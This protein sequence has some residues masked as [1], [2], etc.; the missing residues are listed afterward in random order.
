MDTKAV[1][2]GLGKM[3]RMFGGLAA[4]AGKA[5]KMGG[6]GILAGAGMIGAAAAAVGAITIGTAKWAKNLKNISNQTGVSVKDTLALREAFKAAGVE[7]SDNADLISDFQEKIEDAARGG[8]TGAEGYAMLGLT[9]FGL[10]KIRDPMR[11]FQVLMEAVEHSQ[12]SVQGRAFALD[13]ILGGQGF[14]FVHLAKNYSSFMARARKD[15]EGLANALDDKIMGELQDV[16]RIVDRI[17]LQFRFGMIQIA[18]ALP[19]DK[20]TGL[21]DKVL[22]L[23]GSFLTDPVGFLTEIWVQIDRDIKALIRNLVDALTAGFESILPKIPDWLKAPPD[24]EP[25]SLLQKVI[26][27]W[28]PKVIRSPAGGG[29]DFTTG[30]LK[31]IDATMLR[32]DRKPG[33]S[34][35]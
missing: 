18:K 13:K 1:K 34:F 7:I 24:D 6:K 22:Q 33:A 28:A 30:F 2:A 32:I 15:T 5:F 3:K 17:K 25:R 4:G 20:I 10:R 12:L 8:G 19:L 14:K 31:S 27:G 26:H 35:A 21:I 29:T 11:Q 23:T 9:A 16:L